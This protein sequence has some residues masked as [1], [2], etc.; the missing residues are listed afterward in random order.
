MVH[1]AGGSGR[2]SSE[3]WRRCEDDPVGLVRHRQGRARRQG[4]DVLGYRRNSAGLGGVEDAG[5]RDQDFLI[6]LALTS[7]RLRGEVERAK[8]ARV[9]GRGPSFRVGGT[10]PP[11]PPPPPP[12][13]GG[14]G[15]RNPPPPPP[16]RAGAPPPPPP[17]PPPAGA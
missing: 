11:P 16:P 4:P 17:P 3:A 10:P 6:R 1:E 8:R 13:R 7:P 2:P 15:G 5:E 14:G 12:P 9:R